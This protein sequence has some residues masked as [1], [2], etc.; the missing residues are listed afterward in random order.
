VLIAKYFRPSER[1]ALYKTVG[2]PVPSKDEI[3]QD[4]AY[5]SQREAQEAG[6]EIRFRLKVVDAYN[7]TCALTGY[8]LLTLTGSLVDAAHIHPFAKSHN[9]DPN[10]GIALCKNAHWTFDHGLWTLSDDY[11]VIVAV[12]RFTEDNPG[13]RALTQ[14][15]GQLLRLPEDSGSWP[16]P[17]HL[18]W[19]RKNRFTGY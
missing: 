14:Y 8:R 13:G 3:E 18:A 9:N 7:Y 11:R 17:V 10:N 1:V 2:L 19:H 12:G 6:R 16:S 15:H 4:A 5:K